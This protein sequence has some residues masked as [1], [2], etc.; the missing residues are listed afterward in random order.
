MFHEI[1]HEAH[2]AVLSEVARVLKPGGLFV[3]TDS[4]QLGDRPAQ[5][6]FINRFA[7]FAEPHYVNYTQTDFGALA[8]EY[9]LQPQHKEL[10]SASKVLSFVKADPDTQLASETADEDTLKADDPSSSSQ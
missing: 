3:L 5:D 7:D 9:G 10:A 4:V 8:R 1:P 2:R 6:P